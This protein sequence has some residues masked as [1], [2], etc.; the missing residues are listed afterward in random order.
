M[1]LEFTQRTG[2]D[3]PLD[4]VDFGNDKSTPTFVDIDGDG[5]LDA[6]VA[7]EAAGLIF[8]FENTGNAS[9]PNFLTGDSNTYSS[10]NNL[11]NPAPTFVDIDGDED[12]D[13]FIGTLKQKVR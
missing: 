6:F 1:S 8:F 5:D 7:Q 11:S 2:S 4:S 3:N 9:S 12:F 13:A 10:L